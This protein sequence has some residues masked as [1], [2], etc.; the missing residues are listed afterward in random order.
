MSVFNGLVQKRPVVFSFVRVTSVDAGRKRHCR[1][2]TKH[3]FVFCIHGTRFIGRGFPSANLFL[4]FQIFLHAEYTYKTCNR[5]KS[6]R[7]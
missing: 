4:A 6:R 5:E 3:A 2:N 7:E 1:H